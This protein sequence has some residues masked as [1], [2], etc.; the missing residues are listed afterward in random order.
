MLSM[1]LIPE[2]IAATSSFKTY[3]P[4]DTN[5]NNWANWNAYNKNI[6]PP[7]R[8]LTKTIAILLIPIPLCQ[9]NM[10]QVFR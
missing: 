7:P 2:A 8:P 1:F 5:Y 3:T 6:L 10:W 4:L 9:A